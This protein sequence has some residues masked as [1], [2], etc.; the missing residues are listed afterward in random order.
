MGAFAE[1]NYVTCPECL[2]ESMD[3]VLYARMP[4][5]E[6]CSG[7]GS[8]RVGFIDSHVAYNTDTFCGKSGLFISPRPSKVRRGRV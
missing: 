2:G 4:A 1:L 3:L 6:H 7:A 8:F 5:C